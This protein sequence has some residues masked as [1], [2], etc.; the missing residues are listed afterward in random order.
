V[1]WHIT[2]QIDFQ[3]ERYRP[4]TK[5]N[6]DE[7][8]DSTNAGLAFINLTKMDF[9]DPKLCKNQ[10]DARKLKKPVTLKK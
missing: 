7:K 8:K 4:D 1:K 10:I 9:M 5:H 3:T 2:L 6:P